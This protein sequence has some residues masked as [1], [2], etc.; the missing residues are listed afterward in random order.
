MP[1]QC[2]ECGNT[3]RTQLAWKSE[4]PS[5]MVEDLTPEQLA[6]LIDALDEAVEAVATEFSVGQ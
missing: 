6:T 1:E 3:Y 2:A 5:F 4:L